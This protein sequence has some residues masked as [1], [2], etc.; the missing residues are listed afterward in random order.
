MI[1]KA[2][3]RK[4]KQVQMKDGDSISTQYGQYF[5]LTCCNC[6]LKHKIDILKTKKSNE[7]I[8]RIERV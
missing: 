3:T 5:Y 1:R 4:P 2:M 7:I 6:N 8:L